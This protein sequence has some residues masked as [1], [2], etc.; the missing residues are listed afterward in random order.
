MYLSHVQIFIYLQTKVDMKRSVLTLGRAYQE[1]YGASGWL[2]IEITFLK[3][4]FGRARARGARHEGEIWNL[5]FSPSSRAL[6]DLA[7]EFLFPF[8]F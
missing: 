5:P 4:E 1:M 7:P 3:M 8:R 6:R 2:S